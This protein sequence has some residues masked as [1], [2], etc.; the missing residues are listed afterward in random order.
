MGLKTGNLL[1]A[2]GVWPRSEFLEI[3]G[4]A[5]RRKK[6]IPTKYAAVSAAAENG[7]CELRERSGEGSEDGTRRQGPEMPDRECPVT[8]RA[9]P[10]RREGLGKPWA[11]GGGPGGRGF[12]LGD[13]RS[14]PSFIHS[15]LFTEHLL[16]G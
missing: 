1:C 12:L 3:V 8:E 9:V 4:L 6:I 7:P 14:F 10:H 16:S 2:L 13:W 11:G 15:T 5:G